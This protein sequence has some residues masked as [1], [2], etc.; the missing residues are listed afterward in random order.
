MKIKYMLLC[1]G[2]AI[3]TVNSKL[4]I[5]QETTSNLPMDRV[6]TGKLIMPDFKGHAKDFSNY[7]T[8]IT[9]GMQ[10]GPNFAGHYT[11]IIIGCGTACRFAFVGDV[12]N[13]RVYSFPYGGED[14]YDMT[15]NFNVTS[16]IVSVRWISGDNCI[17]DDVSWDGAKFSS[18]SLHRLG[19]RAFC[20]SIYGIF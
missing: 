5:G 16:N 6:Y 19:N 15:L 18:L 3:L 2:A 1:F 7:R 9:E 4:A 11:I 14:N 10:K 12:S 8:R 17:Q 20:E 13:G